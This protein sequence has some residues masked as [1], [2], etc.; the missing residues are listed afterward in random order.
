MLVMHKE[1]KGREGNEREG[2]GRWI[3]MRLPFF[4]EY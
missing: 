1:G 4:S 2:K 3:N